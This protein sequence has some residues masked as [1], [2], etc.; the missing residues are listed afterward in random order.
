MPE[1]WCFQSAVRRTAVAGLIVE[2]VAA[3]VG[4]VLGLS[5]MTSSLFLSPDRKGQFAATCYWIEA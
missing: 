1:I 3:C 5:F 4:T 2:A